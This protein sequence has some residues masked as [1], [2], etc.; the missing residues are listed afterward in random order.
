MPHDKDRDVAEQEFTQALAIRPTELDALELRGRQRDLRSNN[1]GAL[2]DFEALAIAA[3]NWANPI[4]A[5]RGYRYQAKMLEQRETKSALAEARRRLETGLDTI[6]AT[7]SLNQEAWL[8]RGRLHE[9]YGQVQIK[10]KGLPSARQHL[11]DALNCFSNVKTDEAHELENTV[12]N[13]LGA[14]MPPSPN[15]G[16][17]VTSRLRRLLSWLRKLLG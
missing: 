4:R 15:D 3:N 6:N 17:E 14:I 16:P 12:R 2:A 11:S 10:R 9:A 7:G 5:S 1:T 8:E 13:K